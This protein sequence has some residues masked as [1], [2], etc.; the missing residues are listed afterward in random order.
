MG[1]NVFI[2][3]TGRKEALGYNLVLRY[4]EAGDTVIAT[5]RKPSAALDELKMQYPQQLHILIMD[6][7]VTASVNAA[8]EQTASHVDS[9]DILIN[10]AVTVSPDIDKEFEDFNLD[11]IADVVNVTS[12]GA[13]RVIKAFMPLL[14][15]SDKSALVANITSEAGSIGKCYRTKWFD[16]SMS[17]AALN[18][19]TMLLHNKYIDN[20]KLTFKCVHPGWIHTSEGS[21]DAPTEPYDGAETLRLLFEKVRFDKKGPV[22]ITNTGEEYPW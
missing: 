21:A 1:Q 6:I 16:Y 22:F 17:K 19:G 8:A 14:E 12:V 7:G 3:G 20:S 5:A 2:T 18:M 4:L 9:V 15:K 10:N 11:Y 13:L